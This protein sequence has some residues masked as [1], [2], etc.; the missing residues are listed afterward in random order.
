MKVIVY[1]IA[2]NEAKNAADFMASAHEAD[3]VIVLDTGSTDNTVEKL[4][5]HGA[6]VWEQPF[7]EFR[8]DMARNECL[9]HVPEDTDVL[10]SLDLDDRIRP[11]WRKALETAW[12]PGTTRGRY[13]YNWS[14]NPDGSPAVQYTHNRIHGPGYYWKYACHEVVMPQSGVEEHTVTLDGVVYDHRR[15][16]KSDRSY[17]LRLL[18]IDVAENPNDKRCLHYLGREYMFAG[19]H[20]KSIDTMNKYLDLPDADWDEERCASRRFISRGYLGLGQTS[21]AIRECYAAIVEAPFLR[22]PYIDMATIAYNGKDWE[23]VRYW[24]MR[25]LAIESK[26]LG[27]VNDA[28]AWNEMPHDL[29][30]VAC[31]QL[32]RRDEGIIH[33]QKAVDMNPGDPRLI[34]NLEY[35]VKARES[36]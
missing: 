22:E 11:G 6:R 32:G 19:Q 29:L 27:Y 12:V 16:E 33:A 23:A 20:Q 36:A 2:K 4:R 5:K 31:W 14:C 30:A 9:K 8:F 34:R 13:L 28:Q 17:T 18:E 7:A 25:A 35:F 21:E 3:Q 1:A 10:V 26:T 24:C 15:N